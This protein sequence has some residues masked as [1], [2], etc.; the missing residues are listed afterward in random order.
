MKKIKKTKKIN[1]YVIVLL[2][3][4][5]IGINTFNYLSKKLSPAII[6]YAEIETKK[7]TNIVIN[8]AIAKTITTK[9]KAQDIFEI[10]NDKTDEIKSIDFNTIKIN[11]YLTKATKYIQNDIKNIEKGNIYSVKS[12]KELKKQYKK[13]NLEK[14]IIFY[15][16]SSLALNNPLLANIGPK[17]PIKISLAGDVISYI[18]TEVEDYGINNSMIKVSANIK[19]TEEIILPFYGK[20]IEMDAK[21][22]IAMKMI[23]GKIPQYYYGTKNSKEVIIPSWLKKQKIVYL[24]SRDIM[25]YKF[26]YNYKII[27]NYK[28]SFEYKTVEEIWTDYFD[29]YDFILGDWSYG[30]L[31]LK[32]FCKKNNK[33]FKKYNDIDKV[34][35]YIKM[36]CAFDCPHFILE[37][38][39]D[40]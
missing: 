19:V 6:N 24:Y 23:T 20:S 32:G 28:D 5:V 36:H 33:K 3:L 30:K 16:N 27:K 8:D 22:P 40:A 10:T 34:E 39:E 9:A 21:I 12:I 31:R 37:K 1:L 11:E 26:K 35:D 2:L 25:I 38:V 7:F 29:D 17:I 14:G 4:L 13:K 18:S 15:V